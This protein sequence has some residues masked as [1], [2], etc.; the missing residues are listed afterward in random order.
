MPDGKEKL[1]SVGLRKEARVTEDGKVGASN[2]A[3]SVCL[4]GP[5]CRWIALVATALFIS[6]S[7]LVSEHRNASVKLEEGRI[8]KDE[9]VVMGGE[10]LSF[11]AKVLARFLSTVEM[12]DMT[13]RRFEAVS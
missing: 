6:W 10:T 1:V 2:L 12:R 13:C 7:I 4:G 9:T 11:S 8:R 3:A 5:L